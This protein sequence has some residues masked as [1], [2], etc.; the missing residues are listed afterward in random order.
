MT[1]III[2]LPRRNKMLSRELWVHK[3]KSFGLEIPDG[4]MNSGPSSMQ[5]QSRKCFDAQASFLPNFT[6]MKTTTPSFH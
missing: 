1:I 6:P 3:N 2:F 4:C 5:S